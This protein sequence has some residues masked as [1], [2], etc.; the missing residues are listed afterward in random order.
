MEGLAIANSIPV[1]SL[2][3]TDQSPYE[4]VFPFSVNFVISSQ[5]RNYYATSNVDGQ[6][7]CL[8]LLPLLQL[9]Y[10]VEQQQ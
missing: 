6:A 1:V 9:P 10:R 2:Q 3:L 4:N 8:H 7:I 5:S